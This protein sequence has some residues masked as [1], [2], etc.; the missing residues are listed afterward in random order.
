MAKAKNPKASG[1]VPNKA[2]HSRVSYLY[3]AA[4]Y[5]ATHSE[6][7]ENRDK[8]SQEELP[9]GKGGEP[10]PWANSGDSNS[11]ET[12]TPPLEPVSRRLVSDLRSV[13]LKAQLRMAPTMKHL[14]CKNCDSLLLDGS[15]SSV[16]IE[17]KSRGG[18]KPWA[19]VLVRKC[20]TC[21]TERRYPLAAK[22]QKRKGARK[23]PIQSNGMKSREA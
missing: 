22:K 4:A 6:E 17:N 8:E 11:Q 13:S 7:R 18:K 15:T 12:S 20:G 1:S 2:L 23:A 9:E 10:A 21:G 16:G 14:I 19:D 3:Q 5:L